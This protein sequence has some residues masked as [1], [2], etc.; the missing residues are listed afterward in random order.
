M[1]K[2]NNPKTENK[3]R[4]FGKEIQNMSNISK[5]FLQRKRNNKVLSDKKNPKSKLENSENIQFQNLIN[6]SKEEKKNISESEKNIEIKENLSFQ[7]REEFLTEKDKEKKINNNQIQIQQPSRQE[8][9]TETL[10][11]KNKKISLIENTKERKFEIQTFPPNIIATPSYIIPL[12]IQVYLRDIIQEL[13]NTQNMSYVSPNNYF[14]LNTEINPV[15]R[16]ILIDWLAEITYNYHLRPQTFY[17]SIILVDKF[18]EKKFV[19]KQNFQLLGT[20]AM[21]IS[22]KYEEMYPLKSKF[23]IKITDDSYTKEELL[24]MEKLIL[25]VL[26]FNVTYP[27]QYEFLEIFSAL[28]KICH[29][30]FNIAYF[31]MEVQVLNINS[32]KYKKNEVAAGSLLIAM[33]FMNNFNKKIFKKITDYSDED[34]FEVVEEIKSFYLM[35]NIYIKSKSIIGK[36]FL[37]TQF[38]EVANIEQLF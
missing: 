38:D 2:T 28:L 36:K 20:A 7:N 1:D 10:N 6:Q 37:S 14:Q 35:N 16:L 25:K 17:L 21:F 30:T 24:E 9:H 11:N 8:P 27:T 15:M 13:K 34:L 23:L 29:K 26:E 33:K 3:E 31:L 5:N 22:S 32:L 12:P 19:S 18:L 4:K